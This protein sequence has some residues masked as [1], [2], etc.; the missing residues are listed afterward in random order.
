MGRLSLLAGRV[1]QVVL[2]TTTVIG[3]KRTSSPWLCSEYMLACAV[4]LESLFLWV[5]VVCPVCRV[6]SG[7]SG[8]KRLCG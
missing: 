1:G 4:G 6:L 2:S 5:G 7:G 3:S 8:S